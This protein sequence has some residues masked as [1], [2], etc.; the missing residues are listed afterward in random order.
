MPPQND[1]QLRPP[2]DDEAN[3][4][5]HAGD[6]AAAA[7]DLHYGAA[8]P[9]L[10][11]RVPA[12]SLLRDEALLADPGSDSSEDERPHRNTIGNVPLEWYADEGHVGYD[13]CALL[14]MCAMWNVR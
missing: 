4:D 7:V 9:H 13:R 5:E 11:R 2:S 8:A 10:S 1:P 6:D 3:T 14:T 12:G